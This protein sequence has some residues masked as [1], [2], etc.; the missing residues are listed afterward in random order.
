MAISSNYKFVDRINNHKN[1][2]T[3]LTKLQYTIERY[4]MKNNE[5][6]DGTLENYIRVYDKMYD[7]VIFGFP[8]HIKTKEIKNYQGKNALRNSSLF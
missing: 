1:I 7:E 4:L 6:M 5:S 2:R 3:K 8:A